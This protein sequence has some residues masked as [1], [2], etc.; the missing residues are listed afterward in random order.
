MNMQLFKPDMA[1]KI[2]SQYSPIRKV[3][4]FGENTST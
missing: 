4:C 1:K 3:S 2:K